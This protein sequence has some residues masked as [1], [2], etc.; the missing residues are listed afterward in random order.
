MKVS[1]SQHSVTRMEASHFL[2]CGTG[3]SI[4]HPSPGKMLREQVAVRR[5]R[6]GGGDYKGNLGVKEA[7]D[8][9]TME[10]PQVAPRCSMGLQVGVP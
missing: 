10:G 3:F 2:V 5:G 6:A 7:G 9:G 4:V 8:E 1:A